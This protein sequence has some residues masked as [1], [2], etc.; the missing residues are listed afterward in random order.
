MNIKLILLNIGKGIPII[1]KLLI[2]DCINKPYS[3]FRKK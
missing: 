1:I 3:G 2:K